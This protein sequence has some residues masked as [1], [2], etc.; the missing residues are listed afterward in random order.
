MGQT[1]E[2]TCWWVGE[3]DYDEATPLISK[4]R[5]REPSFLIWTL[6]LKT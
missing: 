6:F 2:P 3:P 1:L 5:S 4:S